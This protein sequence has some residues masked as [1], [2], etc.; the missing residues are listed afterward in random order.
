[1]LVVGDK[2]SSGS[3]ELGGRE[4]YRRPAI[5][6]KAEPASQRRSTTPLP[7]AELVNLLFYHLSLRSPLTNNG[8]YDYSTISDVHLALFVCFQP[9]FS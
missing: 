9:L 1:M 4:S 3:R 7:E 5:T 2:E 6:G 8:D